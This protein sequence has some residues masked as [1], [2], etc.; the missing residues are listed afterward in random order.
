MEKAAHS[1]FGLPPSVSLNTSDIIGC[2]SEVSA[3][4]HRSFLY[5]ARIQIIF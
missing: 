4:N 3:W 5:D 2:L 1:L